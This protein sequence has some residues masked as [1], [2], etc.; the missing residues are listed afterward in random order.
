MPADTVIVYG[1]W[2]DDSGRVMSV[3]ARP[4]GLFLQ[5]ADLDTPMCEVHL[6]G[7]LA[8]A[9]LGALLTTTESDLTS[10]PP[11]MPTTDIVRR[12]TLFRA[13]ARLVREALDTDPDPLGP[14]PF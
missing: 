11:T 5:V 9:L 6:T 13:G 3:E 1:D 4:D 10:E 8:E 14:E 2:I 7:E 12:L